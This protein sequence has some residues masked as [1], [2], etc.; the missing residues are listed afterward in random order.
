MLKKSL[1]CIFSFLFVATTLTAKDNIEVYNCFGNANHVVIE[2]RMLYERSFKA[3][4]NQ[5]GIFRNL[6]RKIKQLTSDE[7]KEK[8]IF[9]TIQGDRYKT[10]GDDEGYFEFSIKSKKTLQQG[11][12]DVT[13]QIDNNPQKQR[14]KLP[15]FTQKSFGII[16]DFDDTVIISDVTNKLKLS[17]NILLKNYKQREIVPN[18]IERFEKI[19]S[20]NPKDMPT[21]LFFVTGSPQQLFGSIEQ[22]LSYHHFPKHILIT[23]KIHGDDTDPLLDQFAYKIEQIEA[24]FALYPKM[25]WVMFGDSGEKD[26]EV[27]TF[28]AKKYPSKVKEF[29]IR[30]IQSKE[31]N[32]EK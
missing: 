18:M 15:I 17:K 10:I 22:F 4:S 13:L 31:V 19:L 27:Y 20:K 23:K 30:D 24:L 3:V 2:G 7:I 25:K 14:V 26:R 8:A 16:S 9:A 21:P 11:Y 29:Y 12:E 1:L 28:L 5:D 6:W 32:R